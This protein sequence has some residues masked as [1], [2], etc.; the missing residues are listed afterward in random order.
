[1]KIIEKF[2]NKI[3]KHHLCQMCLYPNTLN[4]ALRIYNI[5]DPDI[6]WHIYLYVPHPYPSLHDYKGPWLQNIK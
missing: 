1:M 4:S 2:T 5:K 3:A 6:Y